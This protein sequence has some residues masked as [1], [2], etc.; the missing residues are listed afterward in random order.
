MTSYEFYRE[1]AFILSAK[2]G[3]RLFDYIIHSM[4]NDGGFLRTRWCYSDKTV[5][6]GELTE[7]RTALVALGYPFDLENCAEYYA[8]KGDVKETVLKMQLFYTDLSSPKSFERAMKWSACVGFGYPIKI[9]LVNKS[10][11]ILPKCVDIRMT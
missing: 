5:R 11:E 3:D 9:D 6:D 8:Q 1:I 2:N 7:I 10:Y 4:D